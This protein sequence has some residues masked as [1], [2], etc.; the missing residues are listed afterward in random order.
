M[1]TELRELASR[2]PGL[3]LGQ[4]YVVLGIEANDL[5]ILN[6]RGGAYIYPREIFAVVDAREPDD[7]VNEFGEGNERYAYPPPLNSVGPFDDYFDGKP[8]AVATFWR[9]MNRCFPDP[10][11]QSSHRAAARHMSS[12]PPEAL[13]RHSR[14]VDGINVIF[15]IPREGT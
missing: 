14:K 13:A 2:Y 7:W 4:S 8:E 5:R 10:P 3:R 9:E 12:S 1:I 6:D 15:Y 11:T